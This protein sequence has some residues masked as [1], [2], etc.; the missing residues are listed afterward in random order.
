LAFKR[1]SRAAACARCAARGAQCRGTVAAC[2]LCGAQSSC[3]RLGRTYDS[4]Q[5][6]YVCTKGIR[7]KNGGLPLVDS[8]FVEQ[9]PRWSA[10]QSCLTLVDRCPWYMRQ[11]YFSIRCRV[12]NSVSICY[13]GKPQPMPDR[14][15]ALV[16][17]IL[18]VCRCFS[19][20]LLIG[21]DS[22]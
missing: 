6:I 17:L 10:T 21:S 3:R 19:R 16:E 8:D 13:A 11:K 14:M 2:P 9:Y 22:T 18:A 15:L 5:R 20:A 4:W 12:E 7:S 1:E